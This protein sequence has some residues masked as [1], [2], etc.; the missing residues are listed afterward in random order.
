[1]ASTRRRNRYLLGLMIVLLGLLAAGILAACSGSA[2]SGSSAT[3]TVPPTVPSQAPTTVP[4]NKVEMTMEVVINQPGAPQ[5]WPQFKTNLAQAAI[6]L[7]A[8]SLVTVTIRNSDL[9]D[10]PIPNSGM[11]GGMMPP[12]MMNRFNDVIGTV[13]GTATI[14]GRKVQSI[15]PEEMAH[16]FTVMSPGM[17]LNIPI[18][19]DGI[20]GKHYSEVTFTFMTP[21]FGRYTYRCFVPCGQDPQGWGGS[22]N[23]MGYMIGT[24][25]FV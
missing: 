21:G 13:D 14:N 20:P 23:T 17:H 3:A 1:M 18:P 12:G 5:D 7:P 10:T 9:G 4:T 24:M 11:P 6:Q 8:H 25:T 2:S 16:T 15:G 19:G 22:M